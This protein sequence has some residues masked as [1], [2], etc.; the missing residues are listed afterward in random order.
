MIVIKMESTGA[1]VWK[2]MKLHP[3]LSHWRHH[4]AF[5]LA[6]TLRSAVKKTISQINILKLLGKLFLVMYIVSSFGFGPPFLG[7][8]N[9]SMWGCGLSEPKA[10]FTCSH[11]HKH[12][13][14]S[15]VI[16]K[17]L[18]SKKKKKGIKHCFR[19][20]YCNIH[21]LD[22]TISSLITLVRNNVFRL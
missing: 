1:T 11:P 6:A 20:L 14:I 13:T 22:V 3:F 9:W 4:P 17:N 2:K 16:L 8:K 18:L 19:G 5:P 15:N 7:N 21:L 12:T 10:G